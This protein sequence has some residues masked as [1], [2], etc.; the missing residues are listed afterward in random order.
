MSSFIPQFQKCILT[1]SDIYQHLPILWKYATECE[2]IL[3][4]GVRT[5]TSTWAFIQGLINNCKTNKILTSVDIQPCSRELNIKAVAEKNKVSFNFIQEN[6]LKLDFLK[7]G[8]VDMVFI[9]TWH[10]YG[11]LKRELEHFHKNTNK[12]II[13]HDTTVDAVHGEVMRYG[14]DGKKESTESGF[15]LEEV[16]KG[17]WPAV[18][19]FL[20][21]HI[22]W[23][24]EARFNH[25]NG[26][27]ILKKIK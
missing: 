23:V 24:L 15:P 1:T 20:Q 8:K 26:L 21:K 3:E 11:Q 16:T 9:D 12:Y 27:T 10:V 5:P 22:D 13:M 18:E 17:L 6:D 25:N 2:T 14:G 7:I 19:E 4:C